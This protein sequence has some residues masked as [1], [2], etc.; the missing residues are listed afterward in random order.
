[1]P[2]KIKIE[3]FRAGSHTDSA[4]NVREW[5]EGDLDSIVS[6]YNPASHEAPV[7]IGHPK[8]NSPAFG[9]V[10]SIERKGKT[11][12]A[13]LKDLSEDF[14]EAWKAGRYK[15]RSISLYPDLALRHVGFLG[16]M[17]PAVKGLTD[18]AF[19]EGDPI[20]FEFMEWEEAD[21]F[22]GIGRVLRKMRDWL[23]SKDGLEQADSIIPE[24]EIESLKNIKPTPQPDPVSAMASYNEGGTMPTVEELQAKISEF[25]EKETKLT[26]RVTA[27]ETENGLL[28]TEAENVK[29]AARKAEHNAFCEALVKEG[30]MIPAN[31]EAFVEQLELAHQAS[32]R[33]FAEGEK[34]PEQKLKETLNS[35]P[36]VIQFGELATGGAAGGQP[37]DAKSVAKLALQYQE[38]QS[39]KGSVISITQAVEHISKQ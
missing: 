32:Q 6:K 1:M 9:W 24:Y 5:T 3:V 27:L 14:V 31:K 10:E 11:L 4:G 20:S 29:A 36:V 13:N 12:Y 17:P 7:V 39:K 8:D 28:K 26:E 21:A 38:E 2:Q 16:G 33:N 35:A 19:A 37:K 15:K 23:I 25:A 22:Q 34:T 18:Y 30:K